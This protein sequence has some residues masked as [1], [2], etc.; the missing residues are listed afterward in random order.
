LTAEA[1]LRARTFLWMTNRLELTLVNRA[2]EIARVQ[3]SLEQFA[4]QHAVP[5]RKLHEVQLA[6]EEHLT[7]IVHYAHSDGR[8][9]CIKVVCELS[10]SQ[11]QIQIEDDGCPFNPLERPA[12]DLTLPFEE[13]PIGGLGVLMIKKSVDELD[14]RRESGK[15]I[16][17]MIKRI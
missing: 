17:R 9:H 14:Y 11:L 8:E 13:R 16:L 3:D 6:L 5:E 10:A 4:G 12:P 2:A 7:N 1:R 15:N